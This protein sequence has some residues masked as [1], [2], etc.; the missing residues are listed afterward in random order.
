MGERDVA[1]LH[2]ILVHDGLGPQNYTIREIEH[3]LCVAHLE[4][5]GDFEISLESGEG[6]DEFYKDYPHLR[7]AE[8]EHL[9]RKFTD[10]TF[11]NPDVRKLYRDAV[12]KE[13]TR[14]LVVS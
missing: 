2:L 12:E 11:D 13:R 6:G 4:D 7:E 1:G 8:K 10:P 14:L 3:F 5:E 9:L